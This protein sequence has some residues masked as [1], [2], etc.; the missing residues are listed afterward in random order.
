MKK[1]TVSEILEDLS[2][3]FT[4]EYEEK[5]EKGELTLRQFVKEKIRFVNENGGTYSD[6]FDLIKDS[7]NQMNFQSNG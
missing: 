1:I 2:I 3:E 7:A 6:V 4:R 5:R